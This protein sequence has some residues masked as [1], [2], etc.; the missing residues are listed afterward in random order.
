MDPFDQYPFLQ[1]LL[2]PLSRRHRTTLA[3]VI[4]AMAKA[5]EARTYGIASVL[6]HHLGTQLGSATNRFYRLLRNRHL[7]DLPIVQEWMKL[8][9]RRTS[10]KLLVSIDWTEW[11]SNLRLLVAAA[12]IGRRAVPVFAQAFGKVVERRSQNARENSFL[13]LLADLAQRERV[14]LTVL[15]D[16]GFRR[17]TWLKVLQDLRLRFVVRLMGYVTVTFPS[18]DSCKLHE[19][20]LLRG[21]PRDLGVVQLR[22]DRKGS[23]R[24]VG[25]FA[26]NA[27]EPWWLAVSDDTSARQAIKLYDRR[28]TVEEQFRDLKGQRF[29][30]KMAWTHFTKP[31]RLARLMLTLG[32]VLLVW[33]ALGNAAASTDPSRRLRSRTKGPRY[34][35]ATIGVHL[36]RS[37]APCI[38]LT[39]RAL[40]KWQIPPAIRTL[41]RNGLGAAK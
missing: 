40:R 18:G 41:G 22:A 32:I 38:R 28:M 29:G 36:L 10:G 19:V 37:G 8:L 35:D 9:A 30:V 23:A 7:D 26:P 16:R 1:T 17:I 14:E 4:A 5:G 34:S 6:A 15:C 3:V 13:R 24:V 33:L 27:K 39:T 31:E 11:H 2:S 12:V 25:Y 21:K 20:A